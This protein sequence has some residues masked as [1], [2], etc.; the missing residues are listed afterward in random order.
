LGIEKLYLQKHL[1]NKEFLFE[2]SFYPVV[3]ETVD[4]LSLE[5]IILLNKSHEKEIKK[6]KLKLWS[7]DY[8]LQGMQ[9]KKHSVDLMVYK[10]K[11]HRAIKRNDNNLLL[12][13]GGDN[14]IKKWYDSANGFSHSIDL[15]I[16]DGRRVFFELIYAARQKYHLSR[17]HNKNP[18]KH[19]KEWEDSINYTL[20]KIYFRFL[21]SDKRHIYVE[22]GLVNL[23]RAKYEET[24]KRFFADLA[25]SDFRKALAYANDEKSQEYIKKKITNLNY[26][27]VGALETKKE[28]D[29]EIPKLLKPLYQY[30]FFSKQSS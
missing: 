15:R 7:K 27:K 22:K 17:A 26:L 6:E 5:R 25:R 18:K 21:D 24:K 28:E 16:S 1:S 9:N 30:L 2:N 23:E 3:K 20:K 13:L 8:D 14:L 11:L 29:F 4:D 10:T 19:L 12:V